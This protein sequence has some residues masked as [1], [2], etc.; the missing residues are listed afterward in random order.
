MAKKDKIKTI[1]LRKGDVVKLLGYSASS[2]Y[3]YVDYLI[4][5]DILSQKFLPGISKPRFLREEVEALIDDKPHEGVNA[6][7][8]LEGQ[9]WN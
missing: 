6:F 7:E 1:L 9:S 4:E 8:P 5:N 3:R 2:G